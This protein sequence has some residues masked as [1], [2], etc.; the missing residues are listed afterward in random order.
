[1]EDGQLDECDLTMKDLDQIRRAFV[2]VLQ[3]IYHPRI[4]YPK[5]PGPAERAKPLAPA[6]RREPL[7]QEEGH[8]GE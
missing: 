5:M 7:V 4:R 2:G 3:G 6:P 8:R 1:V